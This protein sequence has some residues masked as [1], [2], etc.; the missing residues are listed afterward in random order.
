MHEHDTPRDGK[1]KMHPVS[2]GDTVWR[3]FGGEPEAIT[4]EKVTS[5]TITTTVGGAWRATHR[6]EP[7]NHFDLVATS[8]HHRIFRTPEQ[9]LGDAVDIA[10]DAVVAAQK[11]LDKAIAAKDEWVRENR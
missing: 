3:L 10:F 4:V 8:R 1:Q 6:R 7:E 9:A 2:V 5:K 11:R